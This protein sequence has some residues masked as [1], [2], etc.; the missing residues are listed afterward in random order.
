MPRLA[1]ALLLSLTGLLAGAVAARCDDWNGPDDSPRMLVH[2]L[3]YL[4]TDYRGA[5]RDGK[6]L[7][8]TEYR[9]QL[10]FAQTAATLA[11]KSSKAAR[12]AEQAP[13]LVR[14]VRAKASP[15]E[16]ARLAQAMK[17]DVLRAYS[18]PIA[19]ESWPDLAQGAAL[20]A[21][22][23]AV[24]HGATGRG[25]GPQGLLLHP[26]P[27]NFHDPELLASFSPFRA[28]NTIKEGVPGTKMPSFG[29]AFNDQETWS[30]AFYLF[31]LRYQEDPAAR[32]ASASVDERLLAV[33]ASQPDARL[34][35]ALP[36][37]PA[38][39][40]AAVAAVRLH[41]GGTPAAGND[42]LAAARGLLARSVDDYARGASDD[43]SREAVSAYLQG[44]EPAEPRL[45]AGD[46]R[47]V[48]DLEDKMG[49]VR[50]AISGHQSPEQ[51]RAAARDAEAALQAAQASLAGAGTSAAMALLVAMGI[52]LREG[53]E[54]VVIVLVLLAVVRATGSKKAEAWVHAGWLG[55]LGLGVLAWAFSGW[56]MDLASSHEIVEGITSVAAV[57]VLLYV[58][59]WLHSRTEITEWKRFVHGRV[60]Q[61]LEGGNLWGLAAISFMAVFREMFETVLFLRASS[62]GAG[63]AA[64]VAS[65]LG[66]AGALAL[67]LV[68]AWAL[69][70]FS[71]RLPVRE[72]F[73]FSAVMMAILAVILAGQAA[74]SLQEAGWLGVTLAPRPWR[75]DA[76]GLFPTLQAWSAQGV[77]LIVSIFLWALSSPNV[78]KRLRRDGKQDAPAETLQSR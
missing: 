6:I 16:V 39:R 24:C 47:L 58:G 27:A 76:L 74:H 13:Q 32:K 14:A 8:A 12:A 25:D 52:V 77:A 48:A 3:D 73:S 7:S 41:S 35:A 15:S 66:A 72:I 18:I 61:A 51:V 53:F 36:G 70:R 50:A 22:N 75:I 63:H 2:L 28:Y 9:E 64:A 62:L 42:T 59:F 40:D 23:C 19:P 29:G 5:V 26:R 43:A 45:R 30:L 68:A 55:A 33:A 65:G 46:P 21:K 44:V 49:R 78:Q 11:G 17:A 54:A 38:D 1:L 37:D 60:R 69:L 20:F 56:L 4:S 31:S 71:V 34:A 57:V 10:E 67:V